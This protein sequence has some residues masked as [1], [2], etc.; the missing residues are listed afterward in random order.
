MDEL[1]YV[2][3]NERIFAKTVRLIGPEGEQLGVFPLNIALKRADESDLDLVEVAPQ[4]NPPV[5]R[6]VDYS[7]YKYEQEK[8]EKEAKKHQKQTQLKEIR[9]RPRIG[10]HD[11]GIKLKHI[12][13]FLEKKHKVRIR[14]F[15]RGREMAHREIG[16]KLIKNL[17][18]D[19]KEIGKVDR[20]PLMLG[21]TL[22]MIIGPK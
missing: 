21:K 5:C 8:R 13:E 15:F 22:V 17:M 3:V 9:M 4:V 2:R 1:K 19:V 10:E 6:I 18:E 7:K 14:M 12:K 16:N 11:Y 20:N